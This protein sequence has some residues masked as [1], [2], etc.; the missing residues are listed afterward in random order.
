MLLFY[1]VSTQDVDLGQ[2]YGRLEPT[3]MSGLISHDVYREFNHWDFHGKCTVVVRY[4]R[5]G[6]AASRTLSWTSL[7]ELLS[8]PWVLLGNTAAAFWANVSKKIAVLPSCLV[9]LFIPFFY[10]I[11]S[12]HTPNRPSP[13][14]GLPSLLS[15]ITFSNLPASPLPSIHS[16]SL[17]PL[18]SFR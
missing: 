12:F 2:F 10:L 6:N 5:H 1:F 15:P 11:S 14:T 16:L 3:L 9:S 7:L 4:T 8:T 18:C 13:P 17:I